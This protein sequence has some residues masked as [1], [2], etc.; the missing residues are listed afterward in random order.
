MYKFQFGNNECEDFD[1]GIQKI[2]AINLIN[3][4]RCFVHIVKVNYFVFQHYY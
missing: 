2:T 3:K 1:F 4:V